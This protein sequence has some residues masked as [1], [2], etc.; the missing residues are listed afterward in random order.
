[1]LPIVMSLIL[2]YILDGIL[3]YLTVCSHLFFHNI[4]IIE[5]WVFNVKETKRYGH[6][7]VG[8]PVVQVQVVLVL[9]VS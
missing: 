7:V 4:C 5:Y 2:Y 3:E 8:V 9:E 6:F 1:M